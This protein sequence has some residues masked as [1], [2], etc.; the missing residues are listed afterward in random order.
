MSALLEA[1][2]LDVF[3][4]PI[5]MKKNRP[6]VMLTVLAPPALEAALCA[7]VLKHT[8][9]LGVRCHTARRVKAGRRR[10]TVE[11]P[12][13]Q[14]RVKVKVFGG[15]TSV[16]PEYDDCLRVARQHGI[17]LA[18]VYDGVRAAVERGAILRDVPGDVA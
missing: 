10:E 17:S 12:W 14:V 9:S 5:Q 7:L 16:S 13:G 4:T 2:A 6:A 18:E 8:T 11:T 15:E 1:G 3:F